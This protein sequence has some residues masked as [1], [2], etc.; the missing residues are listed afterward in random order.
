MNILSLVIQLT[1][2]SRHCLYYVNTLIG[3][4]LVDAIF[5]VVNAR[6]S[7]IRVHYRL[8]TSRPRLC[9]HA[10]FCKRRRERGRKR[11]AV[12]NAVRLRER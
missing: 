11:Y 4:A 10:L 6:N 2:I 7:S 3:V 5:T 1:L 9:R 8:A 12:S